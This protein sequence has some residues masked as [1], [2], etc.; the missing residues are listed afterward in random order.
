V[1]LIDYLSQI[2]NGVLDVLAQFVIPDWGALINLLPVFLLIGVLGPAISLAALVWF[3]YFVRKPRTRVRF[4][5]GP[6]LAALDAAG[7]PIFPV[8]EPYCLRDGLVFPSGTSRCDVC[9]DDLA[10]ICPM[11]G[12]GRNAENDTCGNCGLVLKIE[13]RPLAVRRGRPKPGGAAAA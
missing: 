2:W 6:Q 9:R 4:E 1:S 11:C 3:I 13:T 10:V 7:S 12:V 5:E 8:G